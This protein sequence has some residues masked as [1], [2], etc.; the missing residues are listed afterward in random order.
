VAG[1]VVT[2][3]VTSVVVVVT[4][5]SA[6]QP[7][8]PNS[9]SKQ[10]GILISFIYLGSFCQSNS[11]LSLAAT[12][13]ST[14]LPLADFY[15]DGA[16]FQHRHRGTEHRPPAC[17]PAGILAAATSDRVQRS[18]APGGAQI[19]KS[20]SSTRGQR[21]KKMQREKRSCGAHRMA[22]S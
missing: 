6:T 21:K 5:V 20:V 18:K 15:E 14:D 2:V 1:P 4:G 17:A 16:R 8:I 9:A 19:G 13:F 22:Q 7:A 10:K 12:T 11:A 3:R